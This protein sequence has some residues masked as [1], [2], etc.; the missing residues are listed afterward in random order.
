V[1][2][3]VT[4]GAGFVGRQ[5][6]TALRTLGAE[7]T[8]PPRQDADLLTPSGRQAAVA[9][10]D[11]ADILV[12]CAWVTRPAAYWHSPANLD[13]V[14]ATLDLARLFAERDGLRFVQV[15]SCAEYDWSAPGAT[16]WPETR[17]CRPHTPY[18]SAK[19]LAWTV[20]SHGALAAANARLFWPVGPHEHPD[21]LLPG[22]IRAALGGERLATGPATLTRDLI[23]VRDAGWAIAEV[24]LSAVQGPVNIGSGR[25]VTLGALA[26][27]VGA[28]QVAFGARPLPA[29][30]PP[31][32]LPDTGRLRA[33][34]GFTPRYPLDRTIADAI[35]H[36]RTLACAA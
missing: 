11:G 12:H 27:A 24:A 25:A 8:A 33:E 15:G 18:G 7:V 30:E 17:A 34:T 22:L 31:T 28:R 1:Q 19:L 14:V 20:L 29:G 21:R 13:W 32:L 9:A 23:D 4:G 36:W 16:P 6:V 2:V 3:L 5:V 35:A 26:A 10:A